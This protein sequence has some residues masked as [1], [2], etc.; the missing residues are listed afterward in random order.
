MKV[1]EAAA[2]ATEKS[3]KVLLY[4]IDRT[5]DDRLTWKPCETARSALEVAAECALVTGN[6]A[7]IL[8]TGACPPQDVYFQI[9]SRMSAI[10]TREQVVQALQDET[11]RLISV[12]RDISDERLQ[13]NLTVFWGESRPILSWLHWVAIHN[14]YHLGQICYIQRLY[15]DTVD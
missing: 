2:L 3:V 14:T 8:Q 5:P 15:G 7:E 4:T 11:S 10:S 9:F 13:D 1:Q 12:L 6:W